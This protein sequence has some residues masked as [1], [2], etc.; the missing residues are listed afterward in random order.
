MYHKQRE[1][2]F[3]TNAGLLGNVTDEPK[4]NQELALL[5]ELS[6]HLQAKAYNKPTFRLIL[7]H[8]LS[9]FKGQNNASAETKFSSA[10][11]F[12]LNHGF[13]HLWIKIC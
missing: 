3:L 4:K 1:Y 12:F 2:P 7:P 8:C 6:S 9:D 10:F 13:R 5:S 11:I